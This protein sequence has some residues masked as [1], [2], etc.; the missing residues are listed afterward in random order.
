MKGPVGAGLGA[1]EK[2]IVLLSNQLNF[3]QICSR[4]DIWTPRGLP[5]GGLVLRNLRDR[6]SGDGVGADHTSLEYDGAA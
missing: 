4:I 3:R 6:L 1:A 5:V 2:R